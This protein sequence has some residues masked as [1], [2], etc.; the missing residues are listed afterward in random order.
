MIL[1]LFIL[2]VVL[3]GWFVPGLIVSRLQSTTGVVIGCIAALGL[4]AAFIWLGANVADMM[5][6]EE[7]RSAF[8]R[9]FN[10]WKIMLLLAPAAALAAR[11]KTT[12]GDS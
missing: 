10:A 3:I 9:G 8:D 7:R 12:A 11:R 4:G 1:G 6:L 2:G 5:G